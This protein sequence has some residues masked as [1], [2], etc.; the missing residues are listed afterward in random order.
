MAGPSATLEAKEQ[1]LVLAVP[2]TTAA[3]RP[4]TPAALWLA[5]LLGGGLLYLCFFPV[6]VGWLAWVAL[7]PWL[8]LVRAPSRPRWLYLAA[9]LGALTFYLPALQ[10]ARV[11]DPR[12]YVTWIGLA[13]YCACYVPIALALV[14]R[15]ERRTP[16]PLVLTFPVVWVTLEFVRWGA[17]GGFLSLVSGSHLHDVPGGFSWYF[18]GHTQHD[19]LE[20]I[21]IADLGGAYAVSF[22]VAAVNA[23][24]FEV[25]YHREG[26]RRCILG[27]AAR[28]RYGRMAILFQ[29]LAVAALLLGTLAYGIWRTSEG[30]GAPGPRIALLQTNVDQRIRIVGSGPDSEKRQ[31]AREKVARSFADLASLAA[32]QH[33]DLIVSPETSYPGYW[34]ELA[35]GRPNFFSR[36]QAR[37]ISHVLDTPVILGMNAEVGREDGPPRSHNSAI[38]LGRDGAWLGRYNKIHRVPFGE[39]VPLHTWLPLLRRLAPYDYDYAVAP[40]EEFTRFAL[41]GKEHARFGVVICYEDTDPAIARPYARGEKVDFLLNI[42]ND[43]WFDG[44]S[45]HDQHLALCRFRAVETRRA[46]GRAVNMGISAIIDSNGRVLAP[47]LAAEV[48]GIPVWEI[49][50]HAEALPVSRWHEYKKVAGVLLGRVP[51]DGRGSF[52]AEWGDCFA[53]ACGGLLLAALVGSSRRRKEATS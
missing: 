32:D 33:P 15:L 16:L 26:F 7:I 4:S 49:P 12:M 37:R 41:P 22:V 18:L 47:R 19:F 34:E 43:G 46:V 28:P 8:C 9:Y 38:L 2:V 24:L 23:L 27:E 40:G 44:S 5:S 39:Y 52:Y 29:G 36:E 6:A 50:D 53:M 45:E 3:K 25:L 10:W 14:R 11:A 35:H 31:A 13:I 48:K 1:P 42:S 30:P 20:A 21:Q 51:V 17:P